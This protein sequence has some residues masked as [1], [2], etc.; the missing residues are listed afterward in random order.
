R[1]SSDL[2][3]AEHAELTEPRRPFRVLARDRGDR[4]AKQIPSIFGNLAEEPER[5]MELIRPHPAERR[6][7]LG[8]P[9][10]RVRVALGERL[11]NF[12][13][14]EGAHARTRQI[15]RN[16]QYCSKRASHSFA[17]A[18]R[19]PSVPKSCTVKDAATVPHAIARLSVSPSAEP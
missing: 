4:L 1:R 15:R 3:R 13:R 19:I 7:G 6:H 5:E 9:V 17:D 16:S 18:P 12:D 14:E 8:E 2:P 11:R 10:P